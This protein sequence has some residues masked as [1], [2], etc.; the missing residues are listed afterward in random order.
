MQDSGS[1]FRVF[2]RINH[3]KAAKNVNIELKPVELLIF[4]K[5]KAGSLLM[6]SQP[7]V[8]IDLPMKYLVWEDAAGKVNI[9]WNDPAWI[10]ARHGITDRGKLVKKM[11]G[12]LRKL[13]T[14]AAGTE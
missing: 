10:A 7:S 8:A 13:A 1:G 9:G 14:K 3:G 4:G 12:A 11:T 2:A 6:Q 5:P